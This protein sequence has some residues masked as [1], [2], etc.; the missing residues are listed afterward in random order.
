M[1]AGWLVVSSLTISCASSPP[2]AT[3]P[4][5]AA[6]APA[7]GGAT[8]VAAAA[9]KG[10]SNDYIIGP[11]DTLEVFVWRNPELSI[12][13]PVRP[14]GKISTPLVENMVA[15]GKTAPQLARDLEGVLSEYVR[16]PKVNIIVTTAASAYSLVKVVGQ[17]TR[18]QALPYREGM[19]VLDAVL[20]VGGLTQFASGNRS[21]IVRVENGRE[22]IIHVKLADL[23]NNGDVRQNVP[24]KPGDVLVVPQS[25]F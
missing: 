20:S 10:V 17:V 23:V 12:T 7:P 19:T 16:Q 2:V 22:T 15:V 18:P 21:R 8:G 3:P 13:V 1:L 5:A 24:L 25:I 4:G 14:D 9:A 11:G 6:A